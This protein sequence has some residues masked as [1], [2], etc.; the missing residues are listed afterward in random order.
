MAADERT[1][2]SIGMRSDAARNRAK[3]LSAARALVLSGDLSLQLNAIAKVAGVGVGTAYRH[4]PTRQA[5][6]ENVAAESFESLVTVARE[7]A[8]LPDAQ[9]G[10][11]RLLRRA[12]EALLADPGLFA[13]LS[14]PNFECPQTL[15]LGMELTSYVTI[16]LDRARSARAIRDEVTPDDIRRMLCGLRYALQAGPTDPDDVDFFLDVLL[17]GLRPPASRRRSRQVT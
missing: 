17:A 1:L 6:L 7:A 8:T 12:L 5:L 3:I 10:F 13:V 4:F 14:S 16:I 9:A 15:E 11:R 2:E